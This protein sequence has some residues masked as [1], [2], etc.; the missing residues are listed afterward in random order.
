VKR[1]TRSTKGKVLEKYSLSLHYLL[2][3]DAGGLESYHEAMQADNWSKWEHEMD[4]EIAS[5]DKNLPPG[6]K[7]LLNKCVNKIKNEPDGNTRYKARLVV[8]KFS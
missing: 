3:T 5:L 1:S 7:A 4:D 6:K 2:L 8:R